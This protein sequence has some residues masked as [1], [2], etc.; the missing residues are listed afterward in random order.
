M[1]RWALCVLA[2]AADEA[3]RARLVDVAKAL[4]CDD[5]SKFGASGCKQ[6]IFGPFLGV[7]HRKPVRFLGF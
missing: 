7:S 3:I 6:L 4:R 2:A 5:T 1:V